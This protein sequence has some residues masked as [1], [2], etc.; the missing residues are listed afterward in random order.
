MRDRLGR[1]NTDFHL[2]SRAFLVQFQEDERGQCSRRVALLRPW[3]ST[4]VALEAGRGFT[5]SDPSPDFSGGRSAA[6]SDQF[7]ASPEPASAKYFFSNKARSLVNRRR[8]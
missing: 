4:A 6:A 8:Q 3:T 2:H 5:G 1:F 7:V